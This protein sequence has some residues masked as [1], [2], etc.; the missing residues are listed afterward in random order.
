MD[1]PNG[2][3][4]VTNPI[5]ADEPEPQA[6]LARLLGAGKVHFFS[7]LDAT[8]PDARKFHREAF[9]GESEP[10][11]S[12]L[13]KGV[14]LVGF[15]VK[16]SD[17]KL[18]ESGELTV[19]PVVFLFVAGGKVIRAASRGVLQSCLYLH[20]EAG[21]GPWNPPIKVTIKTRKVGDARRWTYLS[22]VK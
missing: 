16:P 1:S 7:S 21:P 2:L 8:K 3:V 5:D 13:N 6:A 14:E 20:D 12:Y 10:A 15:A 9:M 19:Y 11:E 18:A 4:P 17:P 22:V